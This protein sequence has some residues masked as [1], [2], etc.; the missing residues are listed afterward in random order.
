VP[1]FPLFIQIRNSSVEISITRHI[2]NIFRKEE[3]DKKATCAIFTQVR[4]K[5][6]KN[7]SR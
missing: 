3:H 1:K 4:N 7:I 2:K 6:G 5:D